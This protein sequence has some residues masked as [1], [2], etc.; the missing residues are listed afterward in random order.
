MFS[1]SLEQ[2]SPFLWLSILGDF[3]L[4]QARR[5][6]IEASVKEMLDAGEYEEAAQQLLD[7]RSARVL[8][9]AIDS[10]F[11]DQV[12]QGEAITRNLQ[13]GESI[14]LKLHGDVSDSADRILSRAAY[15]EHYADEA[16]TGL[17]FNKPLPK[18]LRQM[19]LGRVILFLGC[20]LKED[21]PVKVLELVAKELPS[22]THFALGSGPLSPR[23]SIYT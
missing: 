2:D 7:N 12:F 23:R 4:E 22:I 21:R 9:L 13:Q 1:P 3:L 8:N 17:D 14:L 15:R 16:G 20:G 18:L 10:A 11:G 5:V 6:E 19:L